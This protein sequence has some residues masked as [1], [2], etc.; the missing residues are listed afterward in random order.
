MLFFYVIIHS[1]NKYCNI[2][3][4]LHSTNEHTSI[5]LIESRFSLHRPSAASLDLLGDEIPL[6]IIEDCEHK[7][8][9]DLDQGVNYP[10]SLEYFLILK[11]SVPDF[12]E[13]V[14]LVS[15]L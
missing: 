11:H 10:F 15:L 1:A 4:S 9:G 6:D 7:T 14:F 13:R 3:L 2:Y 5:Y 12:A 8:H